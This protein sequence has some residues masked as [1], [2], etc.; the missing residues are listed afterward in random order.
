MAISPRAES[1]ERMLEKTP[2]DPFLLYGLALEYIKVGN[3]KEG[4]L[5]LQQLTETHPDYQATY[6]QLGQ[7]LSQSGEISQARAWLE[8]GIIAAKNAGDS[9]AA[10]EMEGL[11]M[12]L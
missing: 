7:V 12:S 1:I 6:Q 4:V 11:L 10:G 5:R 9:H 2:N 3:Q 8:K